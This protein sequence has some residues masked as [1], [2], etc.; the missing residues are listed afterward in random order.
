MMFCGLL[1]TFLVKLLVFVCKAENLVISLSLYTIQLSFTVLK[2]HFFFFCLPAVEKL[3]H[4]PIQLM[5]EW[6]HA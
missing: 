3:K 5:L 2:L 6:F 1:F 4:C